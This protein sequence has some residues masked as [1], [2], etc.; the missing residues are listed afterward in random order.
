MIEEQKILKLS[1]GSLFCTALLMLNYRTELF[2]AKVMYMRADGS[3]SNEMNYQRMSTS[4]IRMS[5]APG[6]FWKLFCYALY[7][8]EKLLSKEGYF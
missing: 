1:Q 3:K 5:S 7:Q 6:Y 4:G 8:K 2:D